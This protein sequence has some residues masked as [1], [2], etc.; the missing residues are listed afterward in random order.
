MKVHLKYSL[1]GYSGTIDHAVYYYHPRL[2]QSLMRKFV[3]PKETA[4]NRR[5]KAVMA[6]LELIQPSDAYKSNFKNYLLA[7]NA[8][9]EH[10][11]KPMLS[12]N[13]FYMK[14]LYAMEKAYPTVDLTTLSREQMLAE[15]LPCI[16]L[17]RAVEAGLLP[18]VE[19]YEDWDKQ[20]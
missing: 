14:M 9:K 13:N 5:I 3:K 4:A 15:D 12:W 11:N 8:M 6:N 19:G 16:S 2:H 1:A 17:K 20:I 18:I 7:Y 10:Q